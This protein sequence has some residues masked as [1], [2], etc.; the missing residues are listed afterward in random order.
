M[1]RNEFI[2]IATKIANEPTR[3]Y[4][5]AG[6]SWASWVD[7]KW[8]FDC[9]ILVKA[10]L[11]GFSFNKNV[12]HG[13][14]KYLS[15][16]VPDLGD[17]TFFDQCC[18]DKSTDMSST[19]KG[20]LVWMD[21]HIGIYIGNLRVVEA[22]SAWGGGVLITSM[23]YNGNRSYNYSNLYK[24]KQHG[25]C[26]FID[27]SATYKY[28]IGGNVVLNGYYH[29]SKDAGSECLGEI[30]NYV[31]KIIEI[32]NGEYPYHI[33]NLGWVREKYLSPYTGTDYEQLYKQ[34]LLKSKDLEKQ[35]DK[36][37]EKINKALE[38]LK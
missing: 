2:D 20:E 31:G 1:T 21:G 17:D 14:A 37:Q 35:V 38:D 19:E 18:Y 24:W 28:N 5:V 36:L 7:N 8:N 27:Y 16:G 9:I 6:G 32:E 4:S 23:D 11:W 25:K 22:T 12:A 29:K 26:K 3:Y 13:G 15:N 34:E 30:Y 33:E 10:I